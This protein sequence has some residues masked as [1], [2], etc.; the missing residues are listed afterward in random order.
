M[1]AVHVQ[2]FSAPDS[3]ACISMSHSSRFL[4]F[5]CFSLQQLRL[6]HEL[7]WDHIPGNL[8]ST[9]FFPFPLPAL[10]ANYGVCPL[11]V[12]KPAFRAKAGATPTSAHAF[13]PVCLSAFCNA[14]LLHMCYSI[15]VVPFFFFLYRLF[16]SHVILDVN[17]KAL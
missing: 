6:W 13:L 14:L 1:T 17:N 12:T 15:P 3:L 9:H 4:F 10:G 16:P 8:F 7:P 2:L 5:Y 11:S